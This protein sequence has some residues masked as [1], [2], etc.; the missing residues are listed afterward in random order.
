MKFVA[1]EAA[2]NGVVFASVT[3]INSSSMLHDALL[4][5]NYQ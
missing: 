3:F 2:D 4:K 1:A 5:V